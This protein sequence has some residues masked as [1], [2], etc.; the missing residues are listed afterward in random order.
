MELFNI[1]FEPFRLKRFETEK[2]QILEEIKQLAQLYELGI[3]KRRYE[4]YEKGLELVT[5]KEYASGGYSVFRGYYC[6]FLYE[7]F[8]IGGCNRGNLLKRVTKKSKISYEYGYEKEQLILVKKFEDDLPERPARK[9][10]VS[11]EFIERRGDIEIGVQVPLHRGD[12]DAFHEKIELLTVCQY[13]GE[14]QCCKR[15]LHFAGN[16]PALKMDAIKKRADYQKEWVTCQNGKP[17][18]IDFLHYF[19]WNNVDSITL[20]FDENGIPIQYYHK[21]EKDNLYNVTKANR[22]YYAQQYNMK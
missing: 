13:M 2:S 19:M 20:C 14:Q 15:Q 7:T 11:V 4:L 18:Q 10:C 3:E 21:D 8:S 1:D 16:T 6:P 9:E 5:K 12:M 22:R 17:K